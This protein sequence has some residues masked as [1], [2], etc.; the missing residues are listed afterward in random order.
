MTRCPVTTDLEWVFVSLK[1]LLLNGLYNPQTLTVSSIKGAQN[2]NKGVVH[3]L[4]MKKSMNAHFAAHQLEKLAFSTHA[5]VNLRKCFSSI[6][7]YRK[8]LKP[9]DPQSMGNESD[10]TW[11]TELTPADRKF[12][13]L[14]EALLRNAARIP[15]FSIIK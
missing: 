2:G 12:M 3:L 4:L 7:N 5:K 13:E 8:F 1:D 9:A 11:M 10:L 15:N 6:E 14:W